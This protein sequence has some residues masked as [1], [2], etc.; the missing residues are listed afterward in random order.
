MTK[1]QRI[2]KTQRQAPGINGPAVEGEVRQERLASKD[3]GNVG[4]TTKPTLGL[5][6]GRRE[7]GTGGREAEQGIGFRVFIQKVAETEDTLPL[8]EIIHYGFD[9]FF[10]GLGVEPMASLGDG[11][12]LGLGEEFCDAVVIVGLKII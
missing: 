11:A 2:F 12:E 8:T 10:R 7:R 5:V 1:H 9:E 3:F 4:V 6:L